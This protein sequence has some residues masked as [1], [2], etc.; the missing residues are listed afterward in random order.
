MHQNFQILD[1]TSIC[2]FSWWLKQTNR[3]H[4]S[5]RNINWVVRFGRVWSKF[6]AKIKWD[7][8]W[9]KIWRVATGFQGRSWWWRR[10]RSNDDDDDDDDD[11]EDDND[12]DDDE[13]NDD[14]GDDDK[15]LIEGVGWPATLQ[16]RR[17]AVWEASAQL[18]HHQHPHHHRHHHQ[19]HHH[20]HHHHR[21]HH[22]RHYHHCHHNYRHY[23]HKKVQDETCF[24]SVRPIHPLELIFSLRVRV[25]AQAKKT[26]NSRF[27]PS[28]L[29]PPPP[30]ETSSS[31]YLG[32]QSDR[33]G[34][35]KDGS[36]CW[37]TIKWKD[38]ISDKINSNHN[39]DRNK[40]V[41]C[42]CIAHCNRNCIVTIIFT[43]NIIVL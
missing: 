43:K 27:F 18:H 13:D 9:Q 5:G 41:D 2:W 24:I 33:G 26:C 37:N 20:R 25:E 40:V 14:D 32:G 21:H 31:S 19:H 12:D 28:D 22:H 1:W 34:E 4:N 15:D 7:S 29:S 23:H 42:N 16:G 36:T 39:F 11:D 17:A 6:W 10:R 30:N 3:N 8:W 38:C 35:G